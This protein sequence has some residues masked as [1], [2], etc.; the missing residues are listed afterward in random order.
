M[1]GISAWHG[2]P[3]SSSS[4][5][6]PPISWPRWRAGRPLSA[7]ARR[8]PAD[9]RARRGGGPP[10]A[11]APAT[12]P[13]AEARF[14][15]AAGMNRAVGAHRAARRNITQLAEDGIAIVG[16]NAGEMAERG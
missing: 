7:A 11:L 3:I 16:P 1:L 9:P 13:A 10:A 15:P 14:P 12:R 6:R 4:R 8:R 5:R 2:R